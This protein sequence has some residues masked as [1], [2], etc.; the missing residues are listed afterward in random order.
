M[1]IMS[2][3]CNE[4]KN[5]NANTYHVSWKW[6]PHVK[7]KPP[8]Y[9][10][11]MGLIHCNWCQWKPFW[12]R[13]Q[14]HHPSISSFLRRTKDNS[15]NKKVN[16][17][18]CSL[19]WTFTWKNKAPVNSE[20]QVSRSVATASKE[21]WRVTWKRNW[22][23]ESRVSF[24]WFFFS[25]LTDQ[26]MA[27]WKAITQKEFYIFTNWHLNK[28]IPDHKGVIVFCSHPPIHH[29]LQWRDRWSTFN[30]MKPEQNGRHFADDI[31]KGIF[32]RER[33]C[34]LIHNSLKFVPKGPIDKKSTLVEVMT[35]RLFGTKPLPQPMLTKMSDAHKLIFFKSNMSFTLHTTPWALAYRKSLTFKR[36]CKFNMS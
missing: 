28:K 18:C 16:Q 20:L 26:L 3:Q 34:I 8:I 17:T 30:A 6:I 2:V 7:G 11:T 32:V 25:C 29:Q 5:E 22:T 35:W 9:V 1:S 15:I 10:K 13:S 23:W 12:K 31:F 36:I 24:N 4:K 19:Q 27:H 21:L 33:F 14:L